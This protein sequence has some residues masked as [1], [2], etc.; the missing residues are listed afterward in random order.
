MQN[1]ET[2]KLV[3]FLVGILVVSGVLGILREVFLKSYE[4]NHSFLLSMLG[5]SVTAILV[6]VP[7]KWLFGKNK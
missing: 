6:M 3:F 7:M 2:K 1:N 4:E 5:G